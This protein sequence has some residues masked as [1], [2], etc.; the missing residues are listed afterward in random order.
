MK[1]RIKLLTLNNL[2]YISNFLLNLDSLSCLQKRSLDWSHYSG[3][4]SK[5]NQIFEYTWFHGN[6][7]GIGND[8]NG[9]MAFAIL[10]PDPATKRNS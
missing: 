8:E 7:Y 6:N 10:A 5:N 4:I 3:E 9:G 1:G 2:A